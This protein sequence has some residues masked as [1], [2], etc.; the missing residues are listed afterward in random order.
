MQN[1]YEILDVPKDADTNVIKK[2]YKKLAAKWHPDLHPENKEEAETKFKQ[3]ATACEIL[4][5]PKKRKLYDVGGYD[6]VKQGGHGGHDFASHMDPMSLF[7]M[8]TGG[9]MMGSMMN[10]GDDDDEDQYSNVVVPIQ[11]TLEEIY[12]GTTLEKEIERFTLCKKCNATG[13]KD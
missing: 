3:V 11:L 1:L 8:M 2:A 9:G 12:N 6:A 13:T 4:S 7:R 10:G 5:D